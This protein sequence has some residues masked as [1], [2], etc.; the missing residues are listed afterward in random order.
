MRLTGFLFGLALVLGTIGQIRPAAAD[1]S[2][3]NPFVK[4]WWFHGFSLAIDQQGI[5]HAS[6]RVGWCAPGQVSNTVIGC[7]RIDT[8]G[9]I[10]DGGEA[11]IIFTKVDEATIRGFVTRS[12]GSLL[13]LRG[14]V[15]LVLIPHDMLL[16]FIGF[17]RYL[18]CGPDYVNQAPPELLLETPCGA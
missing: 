11:T 14:E 9:R 5:G 1:Q 2:D 17:D 13:P 3:F 4:G 8:N 6:W 7:D 12:N 18:L 15:L 16:A 10:F